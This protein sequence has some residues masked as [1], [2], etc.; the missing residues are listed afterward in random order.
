MLI[1]FPNWS[2]VSDHHFL[3]REAFSIISLAAGFIGGTHFP[4][5]NRLCVQEQTG[6]GRTAGLIYA[7]DL[8]GSFLGCLLVGLVFIP[9]VGIFQTLFIL[10]LLNLTAVMPFVISWPAVSELGA[11]Q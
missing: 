1:Y 5:A 4:L 2:G 10:A 7:V 11:R 9:L 3:Y 8:L 6:V